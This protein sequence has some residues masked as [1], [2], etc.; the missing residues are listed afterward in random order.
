M[1]LRKAVITLALAVFCVLPQAAN[2]AYGAGKAEATEEGREYLFLSFMFRM[3]A[4]AGF[5]FADYLAGVDQAI[6]IFKKE[7]GLKLA[8]DFVG[9]ADMDYDESL[10]LLA[11]ELVKRGDFAYMN[12]R[13][14]KKARELGAPVRMLGIP[15]IHG[16]KTFKNCLY[17]HRDS[18]LKT[19]QDLEKK[20][21]AL[22]PG[23][24]DEWVIRDLRDIGVESPPDVFFNAVEI[25]DVQS[26][27]YAVVID[28]A[29][30]TLASDFWVYILS[31][32]DTRFKKLV[33]LACGDP[34]YNNALFVHRET[35]PEADVN[36]A[37][38]IFKNFSKHKEFKK[39]PFYHIVK[40]SKLSVA[41]VSEEDVAAME[42]QMLEILKGK[43]EYEVWRA[44]YEKRKAVGTGKHDYKICKEW[45]AGAEDEVACLDECMEWG[46][47]R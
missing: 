7:F 16:R 43:K 38:D 17:V 22:G 12:Y 4:G 44:A 20:R 23:A 36:K 18:K 15:T 11:K 46:K 3:G 40:K 8:F 39:L 6:E 45:C 34:H 37:F 30:V 31:F 28:E 21:L 13:Y 14:Y 42:S 29:D 47:S 41:R 2:F 27:L 24:D 26:Q 35:V 32:F 5:S 33:P 19:L 9:N 25:P 1:R 10:G